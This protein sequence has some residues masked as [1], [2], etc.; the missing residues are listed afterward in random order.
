MERALIKRDDA[1]RGPAL[2]PR[3]PFSQVMRAALVLLG[4][5]FPF[6]AMSAP[7]MSDETLHTLQ[8]GYYQCEYPGQADGPVGIYAPDESFTV[9]SASGYSVQDRG[10]GL[11]LVRGRLVQ[12]TTGP[13]KG[14][15]YRRITS[16]MMRKLDPDGEPGRL[17]CVLRPR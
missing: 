5:G 4:A 10:A 7:H 13:F 17:R 14:Q 2:N 15:R 12:M 9:V 8:P 3:L 1:K 16:N 11:Y 6:A